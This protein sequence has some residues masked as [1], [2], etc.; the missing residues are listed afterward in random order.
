MAQGDYDMARAGLRWARRADSGNPLY[1]FAEA[2]LA[3]KTGGYFEADRLY[4]RVADLAERSFGTGHVRTVTIS[5]R[6]IDLYEK[7]GNA[8]EAAALRNRVIDQLDHES[9][10]DSSIDLLDRLAGICISAGRFGDALALFEA[11][12]ARRRQVFGESHNR[13]TELL[14]AQT[15][16]RARIRQLAKATAAADMPAPASV[17]IVWRRQD[18]TLANIPA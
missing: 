6:M 10:A 14:A 8:F 3:E 17:Q 15:R 4:R 1:I 13:F 7:M 9:A 11:A 12:V 5:A 16:L 2:T 18:E